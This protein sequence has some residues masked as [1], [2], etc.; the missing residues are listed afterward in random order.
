MLNKLII[1][2][3]K[4]LKSTG[5]IPLD[6]AVVFIGPNNSGKT[7]A[8]QALSLWHLGLN[9][10]IEK[11]SGKTKA[12]ERT[13]VPISRA[14]ILSIPTPHARYLWT[15]LALHAS[16]KDDQNKTISRDINIEII[17]EGI[18]QNKTWQCGLEFEYRDEDGLYCR[19]LRNLRDNIINN[20]IMLMKSLR[21]VYL[22]P[23][24]GLAS[25][26]TKLIP[27]AVNYRLG[28]GRT[29]EV[30]RN[31]CYQV[32]HPETEPIIKSETPET[33]W[34]FV[35]ETMKNFFGISLK[36]P[37]L[38]EKGDIELKYEDHRGNVLDISSIGR[39]S[40]QVLLLVV[41]LMNNPGAILL[42][43]EPDAHLEILRQRHI[44]NFLT[45][46]AREKG[47][48]VIVA[49]HSEVVLGEAVEK[50][51]VVAFVGIPHQINDKK[52]L[53]KSL[54]SIGF[55]DYYQAELKKWVLYLE[56][57][58]DLCILQ[59]FANILNHPV[60]NYLN[61]PFVHYVATNIPSRA[62]EHFFGLR[63]AED[64]LRGVAIFDR[65]DTVL[66]TGD[67][68]ETMWSRREIENYFFKPELLMRYATANIPR[69]LFSAN[70][71]ERKAA[72]MQKAIERIIPEI[73]REDENDEYWSDQRASEQMERIFREYYKELGLPNQMNKNRLHELVDY[74][75]PAEVPDEIKEKLDMIL[76]TVELVEGK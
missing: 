66:S 7:T 40:Q 58:T 59:K 75:T 36:E 15:D 42:L 23:M 49:S 17:V 31:L 53:M 65:I 63:E 55:E 1:S 27:Q 60:K 74:M 8:L 26:E 62:R 38:N 28:E 51:T 57:S 9:K 13:A 76:S 50:D 45:R 11:R 18:N 41:H 20:D 16:E 3:F 37:E 14:E 47:S 12:K 39:G 72:S 46:L 24:S 54:I 56:G 64:K 6:H 19:P 32:L 68:N 35:S 5:E 69:D 10:W 71:Q 33:Q 67:L 25:Q 70:E 73:A 2:N 43:D 52:Q 48:Q 61:D 30:L 34:E 21:L 4:I 29:A 44:Y 22:H